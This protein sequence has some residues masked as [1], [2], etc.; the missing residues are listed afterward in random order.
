MVMIRSRVTTAPYLVTVTCNKGLW[1]FP[2]ALKC[3]HIIGSGL[4][5]AATPMF[6]DIWNSA[7]FWQL[8]HAFIR[9][10]VH[11]LLLGIAPVRMPE[12]VLAL[13][14]IE[15]YSWVASHLDAHEGQG[16][17]V[18]RSSSCPASWQRRCTKITIDVPWI[19]AVLTWSCSSL[20]WSHFLSDKK[21]VGQNQVLRQ[22]FIMPPCL[23]NHLSKH[24]RS[25]SYPWSRFW[26]PQ[27]F[28]R[29]CFWLKNLHIPAVR[30]EKSQVS[31]KH[32]PT[33]THTHRN[34]YTK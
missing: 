20:R 21:Q 2:C 27:R 9:T 11:V 6:F 19:T 5:N 13:A 8:P 16:A 12:K 1:V 28:H 4:W 17:K 10:F 31:I 26:N 25:V 15:S 22:T 14:L 7:S 33:H 32:T 18:V 34:A 30:K 23:S 29:N 24:K 3:A